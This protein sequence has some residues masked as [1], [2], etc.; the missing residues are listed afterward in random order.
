MVYSKIEVGLK[1]TVKEVSESIFQIEKELNLLSKQIQ[2]VYF[3]KLV[4]FGLYRSLQSK[5]SLIQETVHEKELSFIDKIKAVF[6]RMK[7]TYLNS[8]FS[9]TSQVD[10]LV[11]EHGRKV[12]V[13]DGYIDIYTKYKIEE[14]ES[15]NINYETVDR[16]YQG[17]HYHKA[18]KDRSYFENITIGFLLKKLL[19]KINLNS[20]EKKLIQSIEA[21]IQLLLDIDIKIEGIIQKSINVFKL[22]KEQYRKM[23][24]KRGVKQV[25][26]VVSYTH[27]ALI[28]ACQELGI[29]CIEIQHGTI[30]EVHLGYSFPN[31]RKV[32]YFPDK[33]E[34][35][36]KYWQ[37]ITPLPLESKNILI[38][39]YPYL[40]DT[41]NLFKDVER[42]DN[43][44]LFLSQGTIGPELAKIAYNFAKENK[45]Y[46]I[47]YKLHPGE[48]ERWRQDYHILLEAV[49]LH[50]FEIIQNEKHLY[51][52]MKESKY[53][54]GV[55]STSIF[56]SLP[57]DCKIILV[58]LPGMSET[59][60]KLIEIGVAKKA[61]S[62]EEIKIAIED[63]NFV[64]VN[65][66]YF[67]K[68]INL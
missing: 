33:L 8:V 66:D 39:G 7:N 34:L 52:I 44:M 67:F 30:R 10:V 32:P 23:L 40:Y 48:F 11:V 63:N 17:K 25:Y 2:G 12:L 4:R 50:N 53:V 54:V 41:I 65:S 60:Q 15:K 27:G 21:K 16:L 58:D 24:Q 49:Q 29:E 35:F 42:K 18:S 62:G 51:Y 46:M 47:V 59:M 45:N 9:R 13:E 19:T 56:E 64:E 43:Q 57:L 61:S 26:I 5:L 55:N 6:P 37:D 68:D 38:K 1:L 22:K 36:G 3:W 14:L 20:K 28:A 31:D